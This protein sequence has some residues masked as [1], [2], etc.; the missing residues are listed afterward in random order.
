MKSTGRSTRPRS[1]SALAGGTGAF[2]PAWAMRDAR[3]LRD[4]NPPHGLR[5][6]NEITWIHAI[7]GTVGVRP[8]RAPCAPMPGWREN[9]RDD[10]LGRRFQ[11]DCL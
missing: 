7:V 6:S 3:M 1:R 2:I 10:R 5:V 11:L 8:H 9:E 4:H